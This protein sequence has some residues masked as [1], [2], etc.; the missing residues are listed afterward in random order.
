M[1]KLITNTKK[2]Q[3]MQIGNIDIDL[4]DQ[5]IAVTINQGDMDPVYYFILANEGKLDM[6]F[7]EPEDF[8]TLGYIRKNLRSLDGSLDLNS[9][10]KGSNVCDIFYT[11]RVGSVDLHLEFNKGHTLSFVF[12]CD[13]E[14]EV[15]T[16]AGTIKLTPL[17]GHRIRH[18]YNV[19][20]LE[21]TDNDLDFTGLSV[22]GSV[23]EPVCLM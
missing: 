17:N 23:D 15:T 4:V 9:K 20:E 21:D 7:F 5:S 19:S 13:G 3:K 6:K 12:I 8:M 16:T 22:R 14:A 1:Y 18:E 11:Y 10:Y 2:Y